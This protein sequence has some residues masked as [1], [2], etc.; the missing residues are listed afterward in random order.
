MHCVSQYLI[1]D[2]TAVLNYGSPVINFFPQT[3]G[4]TKDILV[5]EDF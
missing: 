2:S 4:Q 3:K 5:V 1:G